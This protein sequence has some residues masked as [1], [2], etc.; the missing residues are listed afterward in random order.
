MFSLFFNNPDLTQNQLRTLYND[1]QQTDGSCLAASALACEAWHRASNP[2]RPPRRCAKR[3]PREQ[4]QPPRR[5]ASSQG[6][7]AWQRPLRNHHASSQGLRAGD[8]LCA[9]ATRAAGASARE[10]SGVCAS[11]PWRS[12]E[13]MTQACPTTGVGAQTCPSGVRVEGA[14]RPDLHAGIS[15]S[16]EAQRCHKGWWP[17]KSSIAAAW[18]DVVT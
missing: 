10:S 13:K 16:L 11:S 14:Q 4:P 3:A 18:R 15:Q 6:L 12:E 5:D 8:G 1:K 2:L 17:A 9:T 7:R